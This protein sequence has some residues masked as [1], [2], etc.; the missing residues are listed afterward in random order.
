MDCEICANGNKL[1]PYIHKGRETERQ[2]N[3]LCAV[4]TYTTHIIS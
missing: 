3:G 2:Y 1:S 4:M